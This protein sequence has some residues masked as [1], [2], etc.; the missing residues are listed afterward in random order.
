MCTATFKYIMTILFLLLAVHVEA[1]D[2][3]NEKELE[4]ALIEVVYKR[5]MAIDT[6]YTDSI[7]ETNMLTLLAGKSTSCFYSAPRKTNDSLATVK[8][9]E[10]VQMMMKDIKI[11][12]QASSFVRDVIFKNYPA[13]KVTVHNRYALENWEYVE[14]WQKPIWQITDS[15][16]T[17]LGYE[18]VQ[19]ISDYRGR[20]WIVWFTP[21]IPINDGPWKLCGLPG[22]ILEAHDSRNHYH[23]TAVSIKPNPKT[24]VVYF[25]YSDRLSTNRIASLKERRKALKVSIR[26]MMLSSG[27]YKIDPKKIKIS[28]EEHCN[29]DFEETDYPHN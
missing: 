5:T 25:D 22:L 12:A 7:Y 6:L 19:A 4:Q 24:K 23:F 29:Y 17:I 11:F 18:C 3:M 8:G 26:S 1:K 20:R 28:N 14:D 15:T 10:Y 2:K 13:G 21:E 27:M 16:T 9:F